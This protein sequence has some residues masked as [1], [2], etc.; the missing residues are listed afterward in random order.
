MVAGDLDDSLA[1]PPVRP[2]LDAGLREAMTHESHGATPPGTHRT[3][4]RDEQKLDHLM[5]GPE[6]WERVTSVGGE[7]R[8]VWAPR[9]F[10][11]FD[12]VTSKDFPVLRHDHVQGRADHASDHAALFADLAL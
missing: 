11:S 2:P 12:T 9:T 8:G 6:S 1:S 3:G 5:F 10:P 7:R 4:E